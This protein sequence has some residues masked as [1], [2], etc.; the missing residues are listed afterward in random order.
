MYFL[1]D[2]C[3]SIF[4]LVYIFKEYV[5]VD[6]VLLNIGRDCCIVL[7]LM[8]PFMRDF[9]PMGYITQLCMSS[10]NSFDK[11]QNDTQAYC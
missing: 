3:K 7:V 11:L 2:I 5:F 10:K 1:C 6:E 4:I 9:R 8:S